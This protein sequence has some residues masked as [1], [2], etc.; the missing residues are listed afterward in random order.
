MTMN[1]LRRQMVL[2]AGL[3]ALVVIASMLVTSRAQSGL[4]LAVT[5]H[6]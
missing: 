1:A 6:S 3:V 5:K 4:V 2:T